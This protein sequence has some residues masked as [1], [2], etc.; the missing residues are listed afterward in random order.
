[1]MTEEYKNELIKKFVDNKISA[2]EYHLLELAA[3]DDPFLFDA[4]EGYSIVKTTKPSKHS[5][6]IFAKVHKYLQEKRNRKPWL[7][8]VAASLTALIIFSTIIIRSTSIDTENEI[9][10]STTVQKNNEILPETIL[11]EQQELAYHDDQPKKIV[12]EDVSEFKMPRTAIKTYEKVLKNEIQSLPQYTSV[13]EENASK[14]EDENLVLNEQQENFSKP[15]TKDMRSE[16]VPPIEISNNDQ[17]LK[18]DTKQ[19]KESYQS[20][21]SN[22]NIKTIRGKVMDNNG[23]ALIG[24]NIYAKGSGTITDVDGNFTLQIDTSVSEATINYVGYETQ[25]LSLSPENKFHT[26]KLTESPN[27]LDEIVMTGALA[28]ARSKKSTSTKSKGSKDVFVNK[29]KESLKNVLIKNNYSQD[30]KVE[31]ELLISHKLKID[32][33]KI[34]KSSDVDS[35]ENLKK[36]IKNHRKELP[37]NYNGTYYFLIEVPQKEIIKR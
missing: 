35:N 15:K 29:V 12:K 19:T 31:F 8:L 7:I 34:I 16:T 30:Y 9:V 22:S 1:M 17:Q 18:V 21:R 14:I 37:E 6:H 13:I 2:K 4:L 28:G 26:I 25:K 23:Q 5:D 24:A 36:I 11:Q 3:L 27:T 32:E 20:N 10:Q 33:I